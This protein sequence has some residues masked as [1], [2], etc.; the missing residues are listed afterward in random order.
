MIGKM[1]VVT[2][3]YDGLGYKEN[4]KKY[5]EKAY[6]KVIKLIA[7][8][9]NTVDFYITDFFIPEYMS[10]NND[11]IHYGFLKV[12]RDNITLLQS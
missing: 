10:E 9:L 2:N 7:L 5:I 6:N 12:S 11:Y 1:A 3:I 4:D 8:V